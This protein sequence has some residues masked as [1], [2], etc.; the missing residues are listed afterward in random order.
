VATRTRHC[1]ADLP[2]LRAAHDKN[3][4][5]RDMKPENIFLIHREGRPEFVKILDFASPRSWAWTRTARA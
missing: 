2:S 4:V 3:I 1:D 5:H